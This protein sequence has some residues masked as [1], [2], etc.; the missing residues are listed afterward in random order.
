ME[1]TYHIVLERATLRLDGVVPCQFII[2][3][4]N[5]VVTVGVR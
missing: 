4:D 3:I 2:L 5:L 1:N